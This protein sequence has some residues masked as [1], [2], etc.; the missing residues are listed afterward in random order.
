MAL[1]ATDSFTPGAAGTDLPVYSASWTNAYAATAD[2]LELDGSGNARTATN[3]DCACRWTADTFGAAHYSEVALTNPISGITHRV[4]PTARMA[5]T[6]NFY[7][8]YAG[9]DQLEIYEVVGGV[10]TDLGSTVAL[11]WGSASHTLRMSAQG[12][13]LTINY[14][15]ASTTRTDSSHSTGSCGVSG[16]TS[17]GTGQSTIQSWIA[18]N[19]AA[20]PVS[21]ASTGTKS[22]GVTA[23]PLLVP[24]PTGLAAKDMLVYGANAY[25][26]TATVTTPAGWT[27]AGDL[28]GGTGTAADAHTGRIHS[29]YKE[30]VGTESGNLSVALG[31]TLSGA[32]GQMVAYRLGDTTDSWDVASTT[33]T[34]DTHAA[35]RAVTGSGTLSFDVD[36][37]LLAFVAT[38]TDTSLTVTAPALTATGITFGTTNRL[39]SGAGVISGNDGNIE[40]FEATVTA[41]TGTQ[42]PSLAFTTATSQCGPVSFVRLRGVPAAGGTPSALPIRRRNPQLTYR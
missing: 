32:L 17:S 19:L 12:S 6:G 2:V 13:L 31:G 23:T 8:V 27:A 16:W 15:A 25:N 42:A 10:F 7:G 26:S 30:A 3:N 24:Y 20:L 5:S 28:T 4:G 33:G 18:D 38:D 35:N 14:D 29:D 39:T 9:P 41:G 21:L 34:D 22:S 1:P 36:D 37:V 40:I 11:S